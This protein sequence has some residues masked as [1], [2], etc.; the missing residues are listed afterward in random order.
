VLYFLIEAMFSFTI[1]MHKGLYLTMGLFMAYFYAYKNQK[2]QRMIG[3]FK[4]WPQRLFLIPIF[5]YGT[6]PLIPERYESF[7]PISLLLVS[8]FFYFKTPKKEVLFRPFLILSSLFFIYI[9]SFAFSSNLTYG[10]KKIET[11]LSLIVAP[12]CYFLLFKT[13][14]C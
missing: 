5:L 13:V 11:S 12:M 2:S 4:G 3:L 14:S 1:W 7:L 10:L 9:L 6:Y 8:A